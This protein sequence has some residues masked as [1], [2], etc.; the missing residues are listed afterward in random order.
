MPVNYGHHRSDR[1]H[2]LLS[3]SSGIRDE[4]RRRGITPKDHA[5]DNMLK[6][7]EI[8][9]LAKQ[10]R[11]AVEAAAADVKP[12]PSKY[13]TVTSR[14]AA[15]LA[16][17]V[18]AAALPPRPTPELRNFACPK[19]CGPAGRVF[20]AWSPPPLMNE[21]AAEP[22]RRAK[23]QPPVPTRQPAPPPPPAVDFVKRNAEL[24]SL[25]PK[26]ASAPL[27]SPP[28]TG[29]KSRYHGRLPPYLL[30]RKL[31]LAQAAAAR[32]DAKKPRD[33]PEGTHILADTE[34]ERVLGLVVRG[35]ERVRAELD[36]MPFVVDT[37]GLKSKHVHLTRQLDQ[38]EAAE[39]AFSRKKVIV[40]DDQP[41]VPPAVDEVAASIEADGAAEPSADPSL[42]ALDAPTP[43]NVHDGAPS[44]EVVELM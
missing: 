39:R 4:Q 26:K 20:T 7:K 10:R 19:P 44:L 31:E 2:A 11:E 23:R 18:S 25:T 6:I 42:R 37:Y 33:C 43:L 9:L 13:G 22:P 3:P 15:Q 14:V 40:A 36:K 35:Q 1:M 8:Q 41:D 32:E 17:P 30:D 16:R 34:R 28:S 5:R 27:A 24:S 12:K 21:G 29:G 38:L